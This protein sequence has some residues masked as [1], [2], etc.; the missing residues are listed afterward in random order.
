MCLPSTKV[1][2]MKI[3]IH[4]N[5]KVSQMKPDGGNK[6]QISAQKHTNN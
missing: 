5:K 6:L 1:V 3:I 4:K 2:I